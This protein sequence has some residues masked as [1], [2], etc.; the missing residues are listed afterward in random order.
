MDAAIKE[1]MYAEHNYAFVIVED[2]P[3]HVRDEIRNV[4]VPK[5]LAAGWP[6]ASCQESGHFMVYFTTTPAS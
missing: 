5:Y 3:A 1:A 6:G 2:Y 4:L